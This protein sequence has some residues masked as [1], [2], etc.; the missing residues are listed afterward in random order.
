MIC[1]SYCVNCGVE[2]DGSATKCALCGTAVCN[3]A[4]TGDSPA[5]APFPENVMIPPGMKK[6]FIAFAIST[7]MTIPGIVLFLV[8]AFFVKGS[9][10]SV[11][12]VSTEFLAWT[13][14][15]FPFCTK[16]IHPYLLWG[17]DTAVV[18]AYIYVFFIMRSEKPY[19][20]M[21]MFSLIALISLSV[22][23]FIVWIRHKKRHWTAVVAHLLLDSTVVSF[24]GGVFAA[25]FSK[26]QDFFVAGVICALCFVSLMAFFVYCNRSKHMRAWI[27]KAFYI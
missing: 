26:N 24:A 18:A 6:K 10:W 4:Q 7:A 2:L 8:N 16:K 3:P 19:I 20:F 21:T 13:L 5:P 22:L 27:N 12:V 17:A 23:L 1:I 11:Y 14:F 15:V 25:Y 9:P